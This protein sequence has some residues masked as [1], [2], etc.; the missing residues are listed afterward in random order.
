[1]ATR[2]RCGV[3]LH[4]R[5]DATPTRIGF[6]VLE[7]VARRMT[8]EVKGVVSVTYNITSKPTSTIE[9]V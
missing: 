4:G 5:K 3:G 9:A 8:A 6:D 7:S 2:S 1:M